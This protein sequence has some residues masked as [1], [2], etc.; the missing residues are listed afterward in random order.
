MPSRLER[1]FVAL[2]DL[3]RPSLLGYLAGLGLVR[4]E[5][6]DV[7][8]ESFLR[9]LAQDDAPSHGNHLRAWLFRVAHNLA[10]DRFRSSTYRTALSGVDVA[11]LDQELLDGSLGPEEL[12][13]QKQQ[14][15]T[16][17]QAIDKLTEKQKH[18]ILLRSEGLRYREISNVLG[19]SVKR[20]SELIQ[21]ALVRI[22][23]DQ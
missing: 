19:V 22:A 21:R 12:A 18:A 10:M 9:L 6:E 3:L 14:W 2:Y 17:R 7:I 13:I 5:A 8:Q 1:D 11:D 23:G 4:E 20:V 15:E 16:A